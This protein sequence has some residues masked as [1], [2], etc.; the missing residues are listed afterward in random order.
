[1]RPGREASL[2]RVR[3]LRP[4]HAQSGEWWPLAPGVGC[5]RVTWHWTGSGRREVHAC[6]WRCCMSIRWL[7]RMAWLGFAA[8][9][10]MSSDA[11]ASGVRIVDASGQR[12]FADIQSAIDAAVDGDVL[13]VGAGVYPGFTVDGKSL[14]IIG[15]PAGVQA[16]EVGNVVVRNLD[17]KSAVI[18]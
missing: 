3:G 9:F 10:S 8:L 6:E 2:G 12:N 18:C 15:V 14:S 4:V 5:G 7:T 1:M 17:G 16:V 11:I 13:L